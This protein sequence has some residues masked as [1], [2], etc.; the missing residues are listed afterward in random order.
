MNSP[1][2]TLMFA[3]ANDSRKSLKAIA[4]GASAVCLDLEDA[5]AATE[6]ETA[7]GILTETLADPTVE[8]VQ[9]LVRV[10]GVVTGLVDLDLAALGPS[11]SR[12]AALVIPMVDSP[13][14]V[15]HVAAA[16]DVLEQEHGVKAGAVRL[17]AITETAKGV[18][19]A[20]DIATAS[21]RLR[22]LLVG[23]G[24]L[25]HD[26]AV[27]HTADGYELFHA[28]CHV[29]LAARA[30]GLESPI[31]GPYL[32]LSDDEGCATSARW[33]RR[34]GFQGKM[35]LHPRQLPITAEVFTPSEDEISWARTVDAAFSEAE[36]R[37]VSSIKLE[38]G[39][40]VDYPVV[41]RARAILRDAVM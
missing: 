15:R 17:I 12:L 19:A 38:D 13:D 8:G 28:R 22:T 1:I 35:V 16:L 31:D 24:D 41:N 9:V 3:P 39:S 27:E 36:A 29:V 7:R 4:S 2:R 14:H 32:N 37:G 5:V 33:A 26:L 11:L 20:P 34:L 18:L 10:N 25:S 6:K 40:F 21:P 23:P 30:A